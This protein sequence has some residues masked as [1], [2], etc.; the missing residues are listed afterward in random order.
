M[1]SITLPDGSSREF[2]NPISGYDLALSISKSLSKQAIAIKV[3]NQLKDLHT[4]IKTDSTVQIIT[5]KDKE[6]LEIIRHSTAHL[7]AQSAKALFKDKI[8]VT[9]GPI[10]DDGF[11]YDFAFDRSFTPEDLEKLEAKMT[12]LV[13]ADLKIEREEI[14]R[15]KAIEFFKAQG[16]EYKVELISAIEEGTTISLY[17]QGDFADLCRGPHLPSTKFIGDGFKLTKLAGAYWRGDSNNPMLQRI[18]GTSWGNKKDLKKYLTMLEEAEKRDHRKLGREM[19]LFSVHEESP[20]AV[21]WHP[22]GHILYRKIQNYMRKRLDSNGY[23]EVNT[24]Q[25]ADRALWEKSGHWE[26]FQDNMFLTGDDHK[27]LAIKPMSCPGSMIVYNNGLKSYRDLPFKLSE[28]GSVFRKESS[29]SLHGIMRVR[30]FTQDDAHIYCTTEQVDSA[31]KESIDMIFTVYKDMGFENIRVKFS[32]RPETRIGTD[33]VWTE[34]ENALRSATE[35]YGIKLEYNQGE[36]AFYGPKLEFV[37]TDAIGRDWQCGTIQ[38]DFMLPERFNATYIDE[39]GEKKHPVMIHRAILGS[40]ERFV[41]IL[42]ENYA[43]NLPLWL[44]PLQA[45]V[46][47]ITNSTDSYGQEVAKKLAKAG[48]VVETDFRNEKIGYKIRENS[49][50]KIPVIITVGE[51]EQ[52]SNQVSIRRLGS[53]DQTLMS[54]DDAIQTLVKEASG[55]FNI[56]LNMRED[57]MPTYFTNSLS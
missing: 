2:E 31:I 43:G 41:G 56:G 40:M 42:I 4:N 47:T 39:Q 37:L 16:E 27:V 54:L 38:L 1:V 52:E 10:I 35:S 55:P 13:H 33:D 22:R 44:A 9:I 28:F 25:I 29:G 8:Q 21:F 3:D 45:T 11:Y 34:A 18:Y 57:I 32:D 14:S 49:R 46:C 7:L 6:G 51:K 53:K 5:L 50:R 12:E 20:G 15:E 30:A 26:K 19:D 24:P 17:K 48:L 23:F 36:G